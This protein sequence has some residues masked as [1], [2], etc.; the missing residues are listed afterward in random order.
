MSKLKVTWQRVDGVTMDQEISVS[1]QELIGHQDIKCHI[2]F[3][4]PMDFQLKA[5]FLDVGH[6]TEAP[7][8]IM[9]FSM[10]SHDII[11]IGFVLASLH[12]VD[13]TD[14]DL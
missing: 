2:I 5:I 14:I 6:M 3:D 7:N 4:I 13:I 1:V 10:V 12:S 8:S 11:C 9:Y